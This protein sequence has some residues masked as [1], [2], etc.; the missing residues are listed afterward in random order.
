M[1]STSRPTNRPPSAK[2]QTLQNSQ[3]QFFA[4]EPSCLHRVGG[5]EDEGEAS[6]S[7]EECLG[8]AVLGCSSGTAV[9]SNLVDYHEV[10]NAGPGVPAPLLAVRGTVGSEE[11]G[12]DHDQIS[13]DSDQDRGTVE[14]GHEGQVHQQ[15]WCG[16]RP[17]NIS[18]PEDLSVGNLS[19]VWQ[20]VLVAN[21]LDNLVVVH[22][23][24]S[25]H[26]EVGEE[27]ERGDERGQDVEQSLLLCVV[28]VQ[29]SF[30]RSWPTYH[31][32]SE[33]HAVKG[34]RGEGH[35]DAHNPGAVS[36]CS[37]WL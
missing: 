7:S 30:W 5:P 21:S 34:E 29:S 28:S 11:T 14:A 1:I 27:G 35:D 16:D 13:N 10:G 26:G 17:V 2:P 37:R 12:Q 15:K 6:E 33:G 19:G 24:T 3:H 23:V 31:W 22:T 32:D 20:T 25:C 4:E 8:L 9:K 36:S 18:C